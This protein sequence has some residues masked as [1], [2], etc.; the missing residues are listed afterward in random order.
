LLKHGAPEPTHSMQFAEA[1]RMGGFCA[2]TP[3]GEE[4]TALGWGGLS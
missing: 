1:L 2:C 3:L 4:R